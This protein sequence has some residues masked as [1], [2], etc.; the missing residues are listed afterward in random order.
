[1]AKRSVRKAEA[2]VDSEESEYK[3]GAVVSYYDDGWRAGTIT[4]VDVDDDG[5]LLVELQPVGAR[6]ASPKRKVRHKSKDLKLA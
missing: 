6:N 3:V 2:V 5:D 1:M 4:S